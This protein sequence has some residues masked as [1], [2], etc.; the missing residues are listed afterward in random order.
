MRIIYFDLDC[1][2]A[3]HLGTYGYHRD[4]SPVIDDLAQSSLVMEN[5]FVSDNPCLPSRVALFSARPGISNVVVAHEWPGCNFR[6]PAQPGQG[7]FYEEYEMPMRLLQR[8]GYHT[9]TFSIF[10]QR[11]HAFWFHSGFSTVS[12]PTRP[13]NDERTGD[14]NRRAI[15]WI[16]QNIHEHPDLFMHIHYWDAH[17]AYHPDPAMHD[18]VAEHPLPD[19]PDEEAIRNHYENEYGPKTARDIMIRRPDAGYTSNNPWMPDEIA[20]RADFKKM[21]DGY[22]G[23][24]ATVDRAVGQIIEALKEE[25]VFEETV[26]II[27]AD[28]G[29]AIGEMGMYFEHGVAVDGV[30]HVPLIVRW[31]GLTDDGLRDETLIYQYDLMAT[32]ADLLGID[33][34]PMWDARSFAPAL[35]GETPG[36]TDARPYLVYGCGLFT[37]QR[38]LR[39]R[40]YAYVQ[41]LNSGSNSVDDIYLFDMAADSNQATNI[42]TENPAALGH[43]ETLLAEWWRGWCTGPNAVADPMLAQIPSF[44]YFPPEQMFAR[45]EYLGRQDQIE[46][47]RRRLQVNRR[48]IESHTHPE[49]RY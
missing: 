16:R 48:R 9:C 18:R 3:D 25:G 49:S 12:N 15:R 27:S 42:A 2:R 40:E 34:P 24:I 38:A 36:Q 8:H 10:A 33:Q 1:V 21:C 6:F 31:P 47:L 23:S 35:R 7:P 26:I 37:L 5:C 11:H 17:T 29:E 4:T 19:W 28:H 13:T 20:N 45:L 43:M 14:V 32:L 30:A 22:D 44:S 46:D 39:T 41:T